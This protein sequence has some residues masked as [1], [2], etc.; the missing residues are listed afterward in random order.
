MVSPGSRVD[1][2]PAAQLGI[3]SVRAGG[4]TRV[5]RLSGGLL[6][7]PGP[8]QYY[9]SE[10]QILGGGLKILVIEDN[11]A[12]VYLVQEALRTHR[13]AFDLHWIPDG[14]QAAHYIETFD[15]AAPPPNLV[16]L[17]LNLPKVDGK[18]LLVKIRQNAH[19]RSTPVAI[20]TSSDS[21]ADRYETAELGATCYIKKPPT[22]DEFLAVGGLIKQLAAPADAG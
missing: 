22:L 8:M 14:E 19:L 10:V 21:P 2:G 15:A 16:L 6:G 9:A 11:P 20:F 12:D 13:V 3:V 4:N 17:D 5:M 7:A 1:G 18:D